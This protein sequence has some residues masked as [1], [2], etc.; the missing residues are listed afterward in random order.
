MIRSIILMGVSGCGKTSV[1]KS[2]EEA[3]GWT[4]YDGDNYHPRENIDKMSLGIP[5]NDQ[6]REPWLIALQDLINE[7]NQKG[8]SVILACSALKKSYRDIL[9]TD[10]EGMLFVHLD[11]DFDLIWARMQAREEHYMKAEML[12]SQFE[13][14]EKPRNALI[15]EIDSPIS[16]ITD[17]II[18]QIN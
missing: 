8:N 2:L 4:F 3:L 15:V 5:L 18:S 14:L 12:Q 17:K 9:R 10:I 1:G 11:G 7:E 6:D 16:S 13:T